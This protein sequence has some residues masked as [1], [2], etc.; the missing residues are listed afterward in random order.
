[1]RAA[2]GA[3]ACWSNPGASAGP[4]VRRPPLVTNKVLSA[5]Q[6]ET[7]RAWIEQGAEYKPHW[8]FVAPQKAAPPSVMASHRIVNDIDRFIVSRLDRE[9]LRQSPEADKESLVSAVALA[10]QAGAALAA[11]TSVT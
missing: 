10:D 11:G 2:N 7:L 4:A 8:A 5:E 9:G 3:A 1:M 6:I